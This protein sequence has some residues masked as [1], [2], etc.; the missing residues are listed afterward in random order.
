MELWTPLARGARCVVHPPEEGGTI[1]AAALGRSIADGG[2][3]TL[4]LTS[5]FFNT[6]I[7]TTP[8]ILAPV[9]VLMVGGEQLSAAHV[10]RALELLPETRLVNGYG[11][12]ECTVF[13]TVHPIERGA[14]PADAAVIPIGRPVGD[15]RCYLLDDRMRPVPGGIPGELYVGGPGVARG[16]LGR[17]AL[18]A[19]RFVPDPF[20]AEPGARLYRTGDR[21]RWLPGRA[22][23][24]GTDGPAGEGARLPHR[25][26]GDRGGA[27]GPAAVDRAV[28]VV[29]EDAPGDARL[30]AYVVPAGGDALD[31]GAL[32]AHVGERMPAY[33]VPAAFV[34]WSAC[35]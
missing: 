31:A 29:R 8:E 21:V 27:P 5:A 23:V 3:T 16:Y 25:A 14:L 11:P 2:V 30:V 28:V 10:R 33:M 9:K 7:D 1:T 26:G 12:S 4:W 15:R 19:E 35:R 34:R 22:G 24:P 6:V 20:A 18:T 17:P 32:R 13:S